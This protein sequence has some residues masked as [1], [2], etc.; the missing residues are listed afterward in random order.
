MEKTRLCACPVV[1]SAPRST[2]SSCVPTPVKRLAFQKQLDYII[3]CMKGDRKKHDLYFHMLQIQ[4]WGALH[5]SGSPANQS[6]VCQPA[7]SSPS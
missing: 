6:A 2:S 1:C 7:A 5:A 3:H 4:L